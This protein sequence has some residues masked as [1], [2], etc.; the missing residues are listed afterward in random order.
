M[1]SADFLSHSPAA[2]QWSRVTIRPHHGINTPLFSI[3]SEKSSGIGEFGDLILLIDWLNSIQFDLVQLLP[4]NASGADP[5]PYN[6][7]SANALNSVYLSLHLLPNIDK[8]PDLLDQMQALRALNTTPRIDYAT[9][10]STKD[11]LLS[12]YAKREKE[13]FTNLPTYKTFIQ[14]HSWALPYAQFK[15]LR[16]LNGGKNWRDWN[17]LG[18]E[19]H[20]DLVDLQLIIQYLCFDQ[21]ESV[22]EHARKKN[23]LLMG[24][25]PI[26]VSSDSADVW[27]NPK[28][29]DL[30][31][32]AGAPPDMYNPEGQKWGFPLY[33][34]EDMAKENYEFWKVRLQS[35][36]ALYDLYRIDHIVGFFRIWAM[37]E[38]QK[39]IEGH[40]VPTDQAL[41]QPQGE[42]M[43]RLMLQFSKMLPIGED[44]G[45]IPDETRATMRRLGISGTKVMR[46]E[47]YWS[48]D[49]AFVPLQD[50]PLDSLTTVSTHDSEPLGLWWENSVEEA[51]IFAKFLGLHYEPHLSLENLHK[52]LTASHH[53]NS[54]FHVN[55]L[56]EYL[57]LIPEL[58]TKNL[59]E[60]R[61]NV[62]GVISPLNWSYRYKPTLEAMIDNQELNKMMRSLIS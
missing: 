23:I 15:T 35:A 51:K 4:I 43:L 53:T 44:L 8:Y 17:L 40:F 32:V 24:D 61:I 7:L 9:V 29:F 54:V 52:I 26:L 30:S 50:Y 47:R 58:S 41:W 11:N 3:R 62:P 49:H 27:H 22:R 10:K 34:Y 25:I 5:S 56:Q 45:V 20:S 38:N 37:E 6:A 55:L 2:E 33:N 60:E 57:S 13:Y 21:W 59:L 12:N 16:K 39:P 28:L 1:T 31:L 46:W 14:N 42:H 48:G 18:L 19:Q 36:E